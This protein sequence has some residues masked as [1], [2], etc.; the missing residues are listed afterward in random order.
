MT[1]QWISDASYTETFSAHA[2]PVVA[3]ILNDVSQ[4]NE[5][6]PRTAFTKFD[7]SVVPA[8]TAVD[9][10][11]RIAKHSHCSPTC[12][13]FAL[14]Y[15]DKLQR[16]PK[17]A[18]TRINVHRLLITSVLVAAKFHDDRYYDNARWAQIGGITLA[19]LNNL[20]L[21]FLF[22]MGFDMG[23]SVE[24]HDRYAREV[25]R[26]AF[27]PPAPEAAP[28]AA[29]AM[30]VE[31]G[32]DGVLSKFSP[33]KNLERRLSL[34]KRTGFSFD[35]NSASAQAASSSLA[36]TSTGFPVVSV[37]VVYFPLNMGRDYA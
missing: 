9:Y 36:P 26:H 24:E 34:S 27:A 19:E 10:L 4:I 15:I 11:R 30:E 2:L 3:R 23:V 8:I 37:P 31:E 17:Y 13:I 33:K 25:C 28:V 12:F 35:P 18:V 22:A 29:E 32:D 14:I 16:Q 21:E 6:R 5:K 20:E 1:H 7:S